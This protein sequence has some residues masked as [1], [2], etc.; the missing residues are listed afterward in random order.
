MV[1][2]VRGPDP[3]SVKDAVAFIDGQNLFYA[4]K[5]AFGYT[6]PNYDILKLARHLCARMG[7]NLKQVRFYT[8]V[9]TEKDNPTW[10]RFW[11]HKLLVMSRQGVHVVTRPLRYRSRPIQLADGTLTSAM[12]GIEK[13][14]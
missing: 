11:Q 9:P 14:I 7:W 3:Q 13:G 6:Y 8:G 5:D 4:V 12:V 2:A 10:H 1:E